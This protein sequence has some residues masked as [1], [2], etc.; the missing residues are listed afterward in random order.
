METYIIIALLCVAAF[1]A[2]LLMPSYC[3]GGLIQTPA[4]LVFT[5]NTCSSGWDTKIPAFGGTSFCT[6]GT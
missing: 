2:V 4:G 5:S 1:V 3:G 6:I